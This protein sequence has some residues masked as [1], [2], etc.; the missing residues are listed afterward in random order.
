[1]ARPYKHFERK[2]VVILVV[3][4]VAT[5]AAAV[6]SLFLTLA[7]GRTSSSDLFATAGLLSALTG[8]IQIDVTGFFERLI[9]HYNDEERYP[10]GP[11]SRITR[12][13]IDHPDRPIRTA[14]RNYLFFRPGFGFWL[15]ISGTA[16]QIVA[17]WV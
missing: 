9:E 2:L 8:F 1:M 14:I 10:Y 16:L 4:T 6:S 13:I 5:I 17:L 7:W 11:P 12:Q 15:V 3:A